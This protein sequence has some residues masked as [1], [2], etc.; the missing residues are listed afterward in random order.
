MIEDG[1][2][3]DFSKLKFQVDLSKGT[4]ELDALQNQIL[5]FYLRA[6][7]KFRRAFNV[8]Y[9]S[10]FIQYL[11]DKARLKE[12][13]HLSVIGATRSGKSSSAM[14]ISI[15]NNALNNHVFNPDYISGNSIAFLQKL[16][17]MEK[18]KLLNRTF[19]IDEEKNSMYGFGALAKRT[20]MQDVQ[21]IIAVN[22]ISTISLTPD[23][24]SNEGSA[25]YGLRTF[26]RN[27]ENGSVRLMLYNLTAKGK[28]GE[29]P[30]GLVYLPIF[31]QF[32]PKEYAERLNKEYLEMKNEW[33]DRERAGEGDVLYEIKKRSA[34]SFVR[35]PVFMG[36]TKKNER[37]TYIAT[38]LGSEFTKGEVTE[39]ETLTALMKKGITFDKD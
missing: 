18:D 36:L 22:N 9:T 28:A 17:M 24:W 27:F 30:L 35:D 10:S 3:L 23:R 14:T 7:H 11:K 12:P 26:G 4:Y 13:V 29:S 38:K 39:I 5:E 15:I 8:D 6:D 16:Q 25:D 31:T 21:N 1:W 19:Q 2:E 32:A 33:V 20:K 34:E 37:L